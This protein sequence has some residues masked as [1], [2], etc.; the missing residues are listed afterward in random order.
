MA[1]EAIAS[2]PE[3]V[4]AAGADGIA[5][6]ADTGRIKAQPASK[7][8]SDLRQRIKAHKPE[9][10]SY[11]TRHAETMI[12]DPA[13]TK[14]REVL[15]MLAENPGITYAVISDNETDPEYVIITFAIRGQAT[16]DLRIPKDRYDGL[17][18]LDL[19]E[20]HTNH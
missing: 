13:E 17:K 11:L 2:A 18:I 1:D 14:R 12:A 3:V 19:I 20:R 4:T 5:L 7:L 10:L 15:D 8:T 9:L 16:C 6:T